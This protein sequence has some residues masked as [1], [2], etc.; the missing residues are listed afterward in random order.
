MNTTNCCSCPNVSFGELRLVVSEF[1]SIP[2]CAWCFF[3]IFL[4]LGAF[5]CTLAEFGCFLRETRASE[6]FQLIFLAVDLSREAER[7]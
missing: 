7:R 3:C 6:D 2:T 1:N 5:T 4:H